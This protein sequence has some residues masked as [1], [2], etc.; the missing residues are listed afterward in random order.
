MKHKKSHVE[1]TQ[2]AQQLPDGDP[3]SRV[4]LALIPLGQ[5]A[6]KKRYWAV[7]E[8]PRVYVSTNPWKVTATFV[9]LA[10]TKED[11]L[12][13][14]EDLKVNAPPPIKEGGRRPKTDIAHFAL[15]K[16][17]E[18]RV[19]AVDAELQRISRVQKKMLQKQLAA[20]QVA[21]MSMKGPRTRR[22]LRKPDYVYFNGE[23]EEEEEEEE[24]VDDNYDDRM[25]D[26][27]D[28]INDDPM[29]DE[30]EDEGGF[31]RRRPRRAAAIAGTERRRSTRTTVTNGHSNRNSN[32]EWR[33][34]RRSSRLGTTGDLWIDQPP[35]K[36]A[37]IGGSATPSLHEEI[38]D[39]DPQ[40]ESSKATAL[41]PN[42]VAL[43]VI[44]GKK[45]SKFWFYA[46]EP[47]PD[48]AQGA[49]DPLSMAGPSR[50]VNGNGEIMNDSSSGDM[51]VSDRRESEYGSIGGS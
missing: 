6:K 49:E 39:L 46:V 26:E 17:L 14:I 37:R 43:P 12:K 36:R 11:Y 47:I 27:A 51:S 22:S 24:F 7:D 48:V 25:D 28:F 23:D 31:G 40:P 45:K 32:T 20:A 34:E 33:G 18:G 38:M 15:I 1:I 42:E 5:D 4:N 21:E 3:Y 9:K 29:S 44:A 41:R 13:V 2:E 10:S 16:V 50:T 30:E 8:S 19:D 35:L